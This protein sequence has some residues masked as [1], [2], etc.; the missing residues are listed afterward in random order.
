MLLKLEKLKET[1]IKLT[2][3]LYEAIKGK[4]PRFN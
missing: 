3:L 1:V 2:H 4:S